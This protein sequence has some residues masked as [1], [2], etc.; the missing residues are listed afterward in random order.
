M[1]KQAYKRA[2]LQETFFLMSGNFPSSLDHTDSKFIISA[3]CVWCVVWCADAS[4]GIV[5]TLIG[6]RK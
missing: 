1:K 5:L 2:I 3:M 6:V 4:D